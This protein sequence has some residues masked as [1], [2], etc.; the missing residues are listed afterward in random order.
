[1]RSKR[2]SIGGAA[3]VIALIAGAVALGAGPWPGLAPSIPTADGSVSYAARMVGSSTR[4]TATRGRDGRVL[5]GA[6]VKG[7]F[8]VPAVTISGVPGG[9]SADGRTLVLAQPP[10]YN[11]IRRSSRFVLLST[12]TL[13][14]AHTVSLRGD[15]GFDALSPDAR[16]LYL[17]Q[18]RS[19]ADASYAV[20]A[21]DVQSGELLAGAIVDKSEADQTMRGFPVARATGADATWVYTLYNRDGAEPFVHALNT[22]A[23]YAVCI[24]L[25]WQGTDE[26]LWSASLALTADGRQLL[27]TSTGGA[28]VA[29]VDTETLQVVAS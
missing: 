13:R 16:T 23:R 4:V 8:G 3:T 19:I 15:F 26:E 2:W 10:S 20:R 17:I 14:L 9:L 11:V 7:V 18:H 21:Y 27:V 22:R 6:K 24:D 25:P 5:R 28:V 12:A 29:R 1:M